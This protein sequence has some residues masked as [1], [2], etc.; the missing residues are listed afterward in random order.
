VPSLQSRERLGFSSICRVGR[1]GNKHF[2]LTYKISTKIG[3]CLY[4]VVE[5]LNKNLCANSSGL[6]IAKK[7][8]MPN[9]SPTFVTK[10]MSSN[11]Q[12]LSK[13]LSHSSQ[14]FLN[15]ESNKVLVVSY[16]SH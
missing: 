9:A 4:I 14:W 12:L 8:W 15:F 16:N 10:L 2:I 1:I 7:Q 5:F 11:K 6:S 13:L 3:R